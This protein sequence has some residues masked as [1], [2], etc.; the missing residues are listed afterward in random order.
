VAGVLDA[1]LPTVVDLPDGSFE[2]RPDPRPTRSLKLKLGSIAIF[3]VAFGAGFLVWILTMP[4]I[5][6]LLGALPLVITFP[7]ELFI[8][9]VVR[10]PVL[11]ADAMEVRAV[12]P[13]FGQRMA[14]SNLALIY[15]GQFNQGSRKTLWMK[16][17]LFV[18]GD[19]KIGIKAA[20][21]DF[22]ADG[23]AEF[24]QRLDVPL[25]GDFTE[26][27]QGTVDLSRV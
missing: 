2:L 14:R 6:W 7:V 27:V 1:S 9:Y 24:A 15:R 8:W 11:K 25:R 23:M 18:A 10:P 26:K 21:V 5:P 12:G 4:R 3:N 13:L 19:G 22:L 17:Y 16:F 20:A